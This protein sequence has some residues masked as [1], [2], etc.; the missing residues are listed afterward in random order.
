MVGRMGKQSAKGKY[1]LETQVWC[2]A[3]PQKR[4]RDPQK[5]YTQH[6]ASHDMWTAVQYRYTPRY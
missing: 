5:M 1:V 4:K 2:G 3:V 6:E